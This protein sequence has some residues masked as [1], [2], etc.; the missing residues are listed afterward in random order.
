M[1]SANQSNDFQKQVCD[2]LV[3]HRELLKT[4]LKDQQDGLKK[5]GEIRSELD[6]AANLLEN[7][8]KDIKDNKT[9]GPLGSEYPLGGF[10]HKTNHI[11]S[12]SALDKTNPSATAVISASAAA[13][14]D[15]K[16]VKLSPGE[17]VEDSLEDENGYIHK[18]V[19]WSVD[20]NGHVDVFCAS[21]VARNVFYCPAGVYQKHPALRS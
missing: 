19:T 4:L 10:A 12:A 6:K 9:E 18:N 15:P 13:H 14:M 8:M 20:A 17:T 5:M 7:V 16:G 2:A 21:C 3:Q 1:A 11:H